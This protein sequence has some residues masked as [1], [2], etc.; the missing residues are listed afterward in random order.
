MRTALALSVFLVAAMT[1][2]GC[3]DN[4]NHET[5][6][7]QPPDGPPDACVPTTVKLQ[8]LTSGD[9]PIDA[10]QREVFLDMSPP[11]DRSIL[12]F[13]VRE[14]ESSPKYG[15]I[16]CELRPA[17]TVAATPAGL[18]CRHE[19]FGSDNTPA[20]PVTVHWTVATFETG[21]TVQR[22]S[23]DTST[24]TPLTATLSPA[25][26]PSSSF[27]VIGGT[28]SGGGGWGNNDF[29][30]AVLTNGST[31]TIK[32]SAPGAIVPWQVVQVQGARV[33][34]G[35]TTLATSDTEKQVA[36]TGVTPGSFALA[37]YTS[38]NPASIAA[39]SLMLQATLNAG[40]LELQRGLGGTNME[41]A[42]EVVTL[43]FPAH[44]YTTD[45][46]VNETSMRQPVPGLSAA[47]SVAFATTQ[48][49]IGQSSG[50]TAFADPVILDRL[51][52]ATI[53]LTVAAG[54][55]NVARA[56][57]MS[58]ASITWNAID[59]GTDPCP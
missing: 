52:E 15:A 18:S 25:V 28:L 1:A 40:S 39:G 11:L 57:A 50:R 59:F 2:F 26:D 29:T 24:L 31:L 49:A 9:L 12:F 46:A 6:D 14:S 54:S 33:Q 30:Q 56:S 16:L 4:A 45:F 44:Q 19:S 43:P 13:S 38:D 8:A 35:T 53:T 10:T 36:L 20:T 47:T 5:N 22:G 41:V 21:V 34:R 27:V 7:A 42:Y 32:Q 37:S 51:G 48:G 3:G 58:T 23:V 17:D 55:V